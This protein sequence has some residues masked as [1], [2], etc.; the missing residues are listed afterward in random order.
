MKVAR[1]SIFLA[2]LAII[3]FG[4]FAQSSLEKEVGLGFFLGALTLGGALLISGLFSF[5]SHL[6]GLMGAAVLALLGFGRGMFNLPGLA[7]FMVG[8]RERGAAP[9]LEFGITIICGML[10]IQLWRSWATE[11]MR[12]MLDEPE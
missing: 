1:V 5:T 7:S 6:H 9:L 2:A 12:R 3:G 10:M 4:F 8:E 11:R